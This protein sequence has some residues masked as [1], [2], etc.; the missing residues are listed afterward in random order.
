MTCARRVRAARSR[1]S[2][3]SGL[4]GGRHVRAALRWRSTSSCSSRACSATRTRSI[5]HPRPAAN[6]SSAPAARAR[7][8]QR[9][10]AGVRGD[11]HS[12]RDGG[13]K[14]GRRGISVPR[15]VT[16]FCSRS[17]ITTRSTVSVSS[18]ARA[19]PKPRT[20][21]ASRLISVSTRACSR[22]IS[23][24]PIGD[25]HNLFAYPAQSN[26]SGVQHPLDWIEQAHAHGWD[27]LLDAAAY[28]PTS[29]ARPERLAAGLRGDV[30]LQDVRLADRRG[31]SV[32][33]ARRAREAASG[34]GSREARS[35][36][37]SYSAST[38]TSRAARRTSRT[39]PSTT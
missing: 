38:F 17:T 2:R 20:C 26:F 13:P 9:I 10:A 3:V 23:Q 11:L 12:E 35:S 16:D 37:P 34:R 28:V 21:P 30:V 25:H 39:A 15:R 24:T 32:G 14:A 8:L 18:P 36:R 22:G 5:R 7:V 29:T 19:A 33:A 1:R 31:V 6:S 4:H 27:V